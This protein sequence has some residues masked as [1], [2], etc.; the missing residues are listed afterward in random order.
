MPAEII[1]D[2]VA[3][4]T[5]TDAL[6]EDQ[7]T[8]SQEDLLKDLSPPDT[9]AVPPVD[10][11]PQSDETPDKYKGKSIKEVISMHQEAEK[12][13]GTQG[14]EVGDLR[15]IVDGYIQTQLAN[16]TQTPAATPEETKVD[17]FEDPEAAVSKAIENHPDVVKARQSALEMRRTT[18]LT[19]LQAK[20]PD[21]K[22]VL[23]TPAFAEWIKA[24]PIRAELFNRAD[25]EFDFDAADE[26][27]GNFRE[28]TKVAQQ[29]VQ[30]ETSV[31]Q[32]AVRNASTGSAAGTGNSGSKRIYRRAD[33][34]KLMKTDPDRYEALND[35]IML[36]YA[37][38]RVR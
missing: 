35:E 18:S 36:A 11:P 3:P 29:A 13:I 5:E 22:E 23:N 7:E 15:K 20:Y 2:N 32:E 17:F 37:E 38:G 34:I 10:Q 6:P 26:L 9:L 31:R 14:S 19:N 8:L 25:K 33:I 21:M 16:N 30:T 1:E 12:L 27:I 24:S 28:R 4:P